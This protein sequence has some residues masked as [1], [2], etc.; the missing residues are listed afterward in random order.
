MFHDFENF[1][2]EYSVVSETNSLAVWPRLNI[3]PRL[4]SPKLR[5]LVLQPLECWYYRHKPTCPMSQKIF[6]DTPW[7]VR[8]MSASSHKGEK[9]THL[10][11]R[12]Q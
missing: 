6:T 1:T 11:A 3:R 8:L 4:V 9:T 12:Q 5:F 7:Y 2:T 10:V